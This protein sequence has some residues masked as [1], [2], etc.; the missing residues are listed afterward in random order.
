MSGI[1]EISQTVDSPQ[2]ENTRRS[3]TSSE[4]VKVRLFCLGT[5]ETGDIVG[6]LCNKAVNCRSKHFYQESIYIG[7]APC[8][9][10]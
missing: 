9:L 10:Q 8:I 3:E 2:E 4:V 1:T 5:G 6:Q 7:L